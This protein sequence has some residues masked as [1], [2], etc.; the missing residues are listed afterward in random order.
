M[1]RGTEKINCFRCI[2]KFVINE[3]VVAL[4][5]LVSIIG[6]AIWTWCLPSNP[7]DNIRQILGII[8][9]FLFG[10]L[11]WVALV[12]SVLYHPTNT[13]E[14]SGTSNNETSSVISLDALISENRER[15]KSYRRHA[16][17][18]TVVLV[19]CFVN[20]LVGFTYFIF[21]VETPVKTESLSRTNDKTTEII[22]LGAST[23]STDIT[24]SAET[25]T[26][27][28]TFG[29]KLC[30]AVIS[31]LMVSLAFLFF[32]M[33]LKRLTHMANVHLLRQQQLENIRLAISYSNE[34][35]N[36][37]TADLRQ[38]LNLIVTTR[39]PITEDEIIRLAGRQSLK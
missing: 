30:A 21:N 28:T 24:K 13:A 31:C 39:N 3:T 32:K 29:T 8:F 9:L 4:I 12:L 37:S 11:S 18:Q 35:P 19:F 26:S 6:G 20:I 25:A 22:K 34:Q 33:R 36:Q 38:I 17:A 1:K 10:I 15:E 14:S 2:Q 16:F 7:A 5:S 23:K 27:N